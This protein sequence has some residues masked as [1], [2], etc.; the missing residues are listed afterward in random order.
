MTD[1]CF[2]LIFQ[3]THVEVQTFYWTCHQAALSLSGVP[4]WG[5]PGLHGRVGSLGAVRSR[6]LVHPHLTATRAVTG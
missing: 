1:L 5:R 3:I 4:V 2:T 6:Q